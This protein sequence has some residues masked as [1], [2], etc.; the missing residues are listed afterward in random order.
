[1]FLQQLMN[2]VTLGSTYSLVALGYTL[3]FGTLGIINMA[4]GEVFMI[5]A[6]IGLLLVRVAEFHLSL[7]IVGAAVAAAIVG[8]VLEFAALRPVRRHKSPMLVTLISTIGF[9]MFLQN[10]A[11]VV[12]GPQSQSF[13]AA[14]RGSVYRL[15]PVVLTYVDLVIIVV[16]VLLMVG[17]NVLLSKTKLGKAMRATAEDPDTAG[18]LGVNTGFVVGV[19]IAIASALGGVA[20][21]LVGLSFA[22][23]PTMGLP[24]GLKGLAIIVLGGM[25]NVPG[26]MIGGLLLGVVEVVT[27][28]VLSSSWREAAA[29]AV[30]FLLLAAKPTGL[31][32]QMSPR[33]RA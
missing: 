13:P 22:V 7:G 20:G 33:A 14:A 26:A 4:H 25:G 5:G 11:Q 27:V 19:T 1:M 17:L 18:L 12:F 8:L 10:F 28:Q 3:I 21:V 15:G 31:F 29:F 23:S 2:G 30:L 16:A 6:F 9:A 24:Y 32:G